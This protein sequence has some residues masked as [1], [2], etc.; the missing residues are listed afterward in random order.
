MIAVLGTTILAGV[1]LAAT[2][3]RLAFLIGLSVLLLVQNPATMIALKTGVLP[4]SR[5][6]LALY[7]K[8]IFFAVGFGIVALRFAA[9]AVLRGVVALSVAERWALAYI[10]YLVIPLALSSADPVHRLGG[11]RSLA[12]LPALYLLGRWMRLP[13]E[14]W[15]TYYR[16]LIG[17]AVVVAAFG[18]LEAYVLPSDFWLRIGHEEYY[19]MKR[20][21]PIQGA[22]YTNM[23]FW[24]PGVTTPIRRVASIT[25]DPLI[26][27]YVLAFA[28]S[29]LSAFVL[30]RRRVNLRL[31][32][33]FALVSVALVLTLSRGAVLT[34]I[35]AAGLQVAARYRARRLVLLTLLGYAAAIALVFAA[36]TSLLNVTYGKG[37]IV[38]LTQGI[39]RG[40][41]APLG[42]GLGTSG[43]VASGLVKAQGGSAD[44]EGGGDS[45]T[46]S[47]ATQ[48]G[49]VGVVLQ[50]GSLLAIA[51]TAFAEGA[52]ERR[53]AAASA[54]VRVGLGTYLAALLMTST[55]NESGVGFIASGAVFVLAGLLERPSPA[56]V[57]DGRSVQAR[58]LGE[59]T[60]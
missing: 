41:H 32:A 9:R 13:D 1:F 22:L 43:S 54:F 49:I 19:L 17:A 33:P 7:V 11:F 39:E 12:L 56:H 8:E 46:G 34:V 36:G 52:A 38:Q 30:T 50:V 40:L 15:R 27:S 60:S 23:R 45:Y 18:L 10:V 47:T 55:V 5:G 53:R 58:L 48:A 59:T 20:G 31:V 29:L 16:F 14:Q 6:P 25:G 57:E 4:L 51:T 21:R 3:R 44:F 42:L 35:L 28:V 37:H 26:S 24:L 2:R